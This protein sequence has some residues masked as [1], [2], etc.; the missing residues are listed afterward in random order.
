MSGKR[1]AR[2]RAAKIRDKARQ[3]EL[4]SEQE[5][6]VSTVALLLAMGATDPAAAYVA[7]HGPCAICRVRV[8]AVA[9]Q[10]V[11]VARPRVE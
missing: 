3:Q 7:H 11:D 10:F 4:N 9:V 1:A 2:R 6:G 5:A 8:G